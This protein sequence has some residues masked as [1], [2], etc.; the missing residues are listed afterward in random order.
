MAHRRAYRLH[1]QPD[2][3]AEA[4][5]VINRELRRPMI[6]RWRALTTD[7]YLLQ[8]YRV[9]RAL[10][11]AIDTA[12]LHRNAEIAQVRAAYIAREISEDQRR[13]AVTDYNRWKASNQ[14]RRD[15]VN[16]R[17]RALV[18]RVRDLCGDTAYDHLHTTLLALADAVAA[19][20]Q[21]TTGH[22]T[23]ADRMLHLH[24]D[25]LTVP[26]TRTQPGETPAATS[27]RAALR[28]TMDTSPACPKDQDP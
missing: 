4:R 6:S 27:L 10:G 21:A 1:Y 19:H 22:T 11:A 28:D 9:L 14:L 20:Q 13:R 25:T 24:L 18:P 16:E 7:E 5:K 17:L 23:I 26:A 2:D 15:E 12:F 3:D 8:T